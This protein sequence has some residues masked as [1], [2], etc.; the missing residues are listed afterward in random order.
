MNFQKIRNLKFKKKNNLIF[1]IKKRILQMQVLNKKVKKINE[2]ISLISAFVD[3]VV[4]VD[5]L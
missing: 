4:V 3:T 1:L 5:P 2:K